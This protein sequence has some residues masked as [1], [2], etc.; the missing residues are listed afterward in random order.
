MFAHFFNFI[1]HLNN[2]KIEAN[3]ATII[4]HKNEKMLALINFKMIYS[5]MAED[6]QAGT[7]LGFVFPFM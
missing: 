2:I 4:S 6:E 3:I 5:S 7:I 1:F